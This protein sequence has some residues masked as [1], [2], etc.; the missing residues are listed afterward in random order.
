MQIPRET[1]HEMRR[2]HLSNRSADRRDHRGGSRGPG[3]P[4]LKWNRSPRLD[5]R[6]LDVKPDKLDEFVRIYRSEVY[7]L[8]RKVP[9]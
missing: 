4:L 9:G 7:S 8:S 2:S 5:R 6:V 1:K 3:R